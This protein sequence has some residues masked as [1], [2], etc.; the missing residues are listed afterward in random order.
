MEF[1]N[2]KRIIARSQREAFNKRNS[3]QDD[4]ATRCG[5][6]IKHRLPELSHEQAR[7]AATLALDWAQQRRCYISRTQ[8]AEGVV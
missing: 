7:D 5:K 2:P 6:Y 4:R 3:I 1:E 8:S